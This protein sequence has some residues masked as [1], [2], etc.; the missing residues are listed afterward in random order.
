MRYKKHYEERISFVTDKVWLCSS[1]SFLVLVALKNNF[2]HIKW[3]E[4]EEVIRVINM[5]IGISVPNGS[6][7]HH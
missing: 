7:V 6:F 5:H 2:R 1:R 4:S 3:A